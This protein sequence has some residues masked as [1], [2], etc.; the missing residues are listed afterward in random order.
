MK[1]RRKDN[2]MIKT[3]FLLLLL[4]VGIGYAYLTS[5]LSITGST[6]VIGNTWDI[7][8]DNLNITNGSVTATTPAIIN[9]SDNTKINYA[10]LL[11]RPGEYYEFTV[12]MVNS[13]TIP[14]IVVLVELSGIDT[15]LENVVD[16]SIV[17]TNS[18]IPVSVNDILNGGAT[19]KIK[20]RVSYKEDIEEEELLASNVDLMITLNIEFNQAEEPDP[21]TNDLIQ[22]L[23]E[24]NSSCFTKYNGQVTDQVGET[25]TASNVYFNKCENKRNIIFGGFCWQ[26]IRT[27]ETG[28]IKMIYNGEVVNGKC[29]SN[30]SIHKGVVQETSEL[31]NISNSYLYGDSFIYD[32]NS[33]KFTLTNTFTETWSDATYEDLLGKFTCLSNNNT[34]STIYRPNCHFSNTESC[35]YSYVVDDTNYEQIGTSVFNDANTG[36]TIANVG[37]MTNILHKNFLDILDGPKKFSSSFTYNSSNNTYTLSGTIQEFSNW[38][39][40]DYS[41]LNNTHYTCDNM[42][43]SC[44]TLYYVQSIVPSQGEASKYYFFALNNGKNIDDLVSEMFN[45]TNVNKYDSNVKSIIESWYAQYLSNYSSKIE[46]TVYCNN[47]SIS[48]YGGYNSNGGNIN[49]GEYNNLLFKN[50]YLSAELSC[51]NLTDQFTV[52]NNKAKLRYPVG[53][54]QAEEYYHLGEALPTNTSY[55]TISPAY[56]DSTDSYVVALDEYGYTWKM[57][58]PMGIRPV[59][60]INSSTTVSSGS[61]SENEPWIIE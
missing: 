35:L 15:E 33:K 3:I 10:V 44:T 20:V 4:A 12:D 19:K 61:G 32:T 57:W 59:I 5:N 51:A 30:R 58:W 11:N 36:S 25:V 2:Q 48:N 1:Y 39:L 34:C 53:L 21:T 47:R 27:T 24:E 46:D 14:G 13:G 31:Y 50:I 7:H 9:P 60:S 45:D 49:R 37:Y 28:G 56:A 55:W 54:I 17:Y 18:N 43:T 8:F 6:A 26:M 29:L 16:Y 22:L 41:I 40:S 52:S 42:N 38:N 23:K